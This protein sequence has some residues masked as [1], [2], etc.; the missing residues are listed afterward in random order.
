MASNI[1]KDGKTYYLDVTKASLNK[2]LYTE[3][4]SPLQIE[5][6]LIDNLEKAID[7]SYWVESSGDRKGRQQVDGFDTLRTS[8]YVDGDPYYADIKVK[9][10]QPGK[11]A[12]AQDVVY[13]LEPAGALVIKR[14]DDGSPTAERHARSIIFGDQLS[15]GV[16][17]T[18]PL[19]VK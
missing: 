2:M 18:R 17:G 19:N 6:L 16:E 7:S 3:K 12:D 14:A 4:S 10:V 8:F 1:T 5:R 11:N 9:V 13:F 15:A